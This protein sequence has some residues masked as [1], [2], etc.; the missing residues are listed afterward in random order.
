MRGSESVSQHSMSVNVDGQNGH[1]DDG[2]SIA[3]GC[4][5]LHFEALRNTQWFLQKYTVCA[6]DLDIHCYPFIVGQLIGFLDKIA[7][8][9]ESDIEGRKQDVEDENSSRLGF[10]LQQYGLLNEIGSYESAIIPLDHFPF[11]TFENDRSFCSL[12]NIVDD[13]RLKFS[14]TLYLRDQKIRYSKFSLMERTKMLPNPPMNCSFDADSSV[15]TFIDRDSILVNLNLGSVTVHFH[16]SSCIIGTVEVPLAKSLLSISADYLDVVCS[17]EGVA[18]SSSLWSQIINEFLWGPLSSNLSP[19][20][21]LHLKKTN[22]G[23]Q[24]SQLEMSFYIQ[25]VSC[26]LPP[27]FL[28]MVIGYFSLPDWSPCAKEQPTDTMN[29]QDSSTITFSFEIVDCNVITPANSV[30]SEF[31]KVNIKRLS[32]AFSEN[33]DRSCVTKNIPSA[34]CISAGKFSDRNLCLD[35]FGCDLSLSLLLLEKDVVNPLNRCQ[36][37][38]LVASLSADVWVRIPYDSETD[39]A[40]SYPVCIMAMVNDCQVDIEGMRT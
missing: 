34:C 29:I 18:L 36:N 30:S 11:T 4:I 3:V 32:V 38:I 16:D 2:S 33:S 15:Q 13:M 12:E 14:K 39:L 31:L 22:T 20:L 10:E 40:S 9:G 26:M 1:L 25:Q 19:I 23:S 21:N 24:N 35:F 27:E 17:T 5:V 7:L 6:S 8:Y 28:A 37:H